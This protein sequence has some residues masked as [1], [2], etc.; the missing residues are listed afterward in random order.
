MWELS[1]QTDTGAH[2]MA[3]RDHDPH[4]VAQARAVCRGDAGSAGLFA[5]TLRG[6][7]GGPSRGPFRSQARLKSPWG[8]HVNRRQGHR[9]TLAWRP[10]IPCAPFIT[11]RS[12]PG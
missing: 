11:E 1:G 9:P 12:M 6:D 7:E 5:H 2:M 10:C 3:L 4:D 8:L